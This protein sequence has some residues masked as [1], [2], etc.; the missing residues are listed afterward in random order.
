[1]SI[2][3]GTKYFIE[4]TLIFTGKSQQWTEPSQACFFGEGRG[5]EQGSALPSHATGLCVSIDAHTV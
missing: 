2:P 5:E 3:R 4:S 1:M